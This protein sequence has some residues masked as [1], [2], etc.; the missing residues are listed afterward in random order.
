M[1]GK[2]Q[3]PAPVE[4]AYLS[5]NGPNAHGGISCR[6]SEL[7]FDDEPLESIL[8]GKDMSGPTCS[9][10]FQEASDLTRD[11]LEFHDRGDTKGLVEKISEFV[12]KERPISQETALYLTAMISKIV[13]NYPMPLLDLDLEPA[14]RL[15]EQIWTLAININNDQLV[16]MISGPL[17]RFYEHSRRYDEARKILLKLI[18]ISVKHHDQASLAVALNNYAFEFLLENRFSEAI[19][20]FSKAATMFKNLN[21]VFEHANARANCLLCQFECEEFEI[22][23]KNETELR[24]IFKILKTSHA[25]HARKPLIL[26]AKIQEKRNRFKTA[27]RL[28]KLAIASCKQSRTKYP[29]LDE[30]YLQHLIKHSA[31]AI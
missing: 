14:G 5:E 10:I 13:P 17:F 9:D 31:M 28:V 11:M 8:Y 7:L 22:F 6:P 24:T 16:K 18:D 4:I 23:E 27:I 15:S 30:A 2:E 20:H 29:E 12:L 19:P 26:L 25:W 1:D 3:K 21:I